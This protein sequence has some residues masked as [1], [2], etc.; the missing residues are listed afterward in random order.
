MKR[1]QVLKI[2]LLI[3][4]FIVFFVGLYLIIKYNRPS[5]EPT[6]PEPTPQP[7]PKERE[8]V[9]CWNYIKDRIRNIERG[10]EDG[11]T[12]QSTYDYFSK[13]PTKI[14]KQ[15]N[16]DARLAAMNDPLSSCMP[17]FPNCQNL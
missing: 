8:I 10:H 1:Q 11:R 16:N 3:T 9:S 4:I 12:C 17:P 13:N 15:F 14:P 7:S 6:P 5:P 2:S